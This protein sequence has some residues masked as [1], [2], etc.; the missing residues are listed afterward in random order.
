[1]TAPVVQRRETTLAGAAATA[2]SPR[3]AYSATAG[4]GALLAAMGSADLLLSFYPSFWSNPEW[5]FTTVLGVFTGLPTVG[6]GLG[7]V[8]V[9]AVGAGRRPLLLAAVLLNAIMLLILVGLIVP[10]AGATR[11]ALG[12]ADPSVHEGVVRALTRGLVYAAG[13]IAFHG[14]LA[15]LAERRR[16]AAM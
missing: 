15:V 10:L 2:A 13:F 7:A 3:G 5:V 6:I 11:V 9:G 8:A 14:W 12:V 4:L 16:R 1:M